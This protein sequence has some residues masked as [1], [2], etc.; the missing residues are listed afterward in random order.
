[1][2]SSLFHCVIWFECT[3]RRSAS[4]VNL[5]SPLTAASATSTLKAAE[6]LQRVLFMLS[7]SRALRSIVAETS[8]PR[9]SVI[10]EVTSL[11]VIP[12]LLHLGCTRKKVQGHRRQARAMA[13]MARLQGQ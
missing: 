1:M 4:D 6:C 11:S 8:R 5:W 3:S 10:A 7:A 13:K 12:T 2:S 9:L